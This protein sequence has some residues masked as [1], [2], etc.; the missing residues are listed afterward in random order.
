[1]S[2]RGEFVNSSFKRRDFLKLA[3]LVP[4]GLFVPK[5]V[6]GMNVSSQGDEKRNIIVFI[7]DA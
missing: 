5:L 4:L 1:M 6:Q 3:G 7:F 2:R